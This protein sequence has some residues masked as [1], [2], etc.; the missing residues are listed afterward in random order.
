MLKKIQHWLKMIFN[1][2][3][4]KLYTQYP[5]LYRYLFEEEDQS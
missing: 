4:N 1:W 3:Y 2:R 5:G